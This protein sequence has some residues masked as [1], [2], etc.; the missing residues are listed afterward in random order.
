MNH[1]DKTPHVLSKTGKLVV[2]IS[3]WIIDFDDYVT[4]HNPEKNGQLSKMQSLF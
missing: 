4:F 1:I 3:S 2:K